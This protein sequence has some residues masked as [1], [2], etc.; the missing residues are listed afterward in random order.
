MYSENS[1]TFQYFFCLNKVPSLY[2]SPLTKNKDKSS[3]TSAMGSTPEYYFK[4]SRFSKKFDYLIIF[5]SSQGCLF[6]ALISSD[7][8]PH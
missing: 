4:N 3:L 8:S 5:G 1:F 2:L 7:R 6:W